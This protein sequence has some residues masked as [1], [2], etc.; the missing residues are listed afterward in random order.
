[1]LDPLPSVSVIVPL[2]NKRAYIRRCLESIQRQTIRNFE[3]II[4]DDGSSD[5][6]GEIAAAWPDS[7]FH[8]VRQANGGPGAARNRG[9]EEAR[10]GL[11]AFLDADDEWDDG[12][13]EAI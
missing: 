10:A 5:G 8:S 4:V 6:S 1:M 3:V 7:R 13:L 12:F 11:I 2:F 9:I